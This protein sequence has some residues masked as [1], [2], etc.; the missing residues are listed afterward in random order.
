MKNSTYFCV[1]LSQ[2]L[3]HWPWGQSQ[4][5]SPQPIL[6]LRFHLVLAH[7]CIFNMFKCRI[8]K[9]NTKSDSIKKNCSD[10]HYNKVFQFSNSLYHITIFDRSIV[11]IKIVHWICVLYLTNGVMYID[12]LLFLYI[13]WGYWLIMIMTIN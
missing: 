7:T 3:R 1:C 8:W 5:R 2:W 12:F 11:P 10:V 9:F 6:M 13:S 4:V